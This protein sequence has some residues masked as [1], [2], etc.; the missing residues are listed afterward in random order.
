M[1][2]CVVLGG[3]LPFS[4]SLTSFWGIQQCYQLVLSCASQILQNY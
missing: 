2:V 4:T 3:D 1:G